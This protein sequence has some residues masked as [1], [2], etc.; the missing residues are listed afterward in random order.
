MFS[1]IKKDIRS[2]L[3]RKE[4]IKKIKYLNKILFLQVNTYSVLDKK[5][6]KME[7][8]NHLMTE[9]ENNI[10][11]ENLEQIK[12]LLLTYSRFEFTLI[13]ENIIYRNDVGVASAN[14]KKYAQRIKANFDRNFS[15]D[16]KNACDY[17]A[18][19]PPKEKI[20]DNWQQIQFQ[21]TTSE[22]EKV[23]RYVK[24]V[25]NNLFHGS[26]YPYIHARDNILIKNCLIVLNYILS[27]SSSN[28]Q[29]T[30]WTDLTPSNPSE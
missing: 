19:E 18:T 9:L 5:P 13:Q 23:I 11:T 12:I 22:C 15:D 29:N 21:T 6:Q 26:K 7:L 20:M 1:E 28:F 10:Q 17:F 4:I 14:W 3:K 2:S 8:I 16:I 24:T 25:R 27:I 30:F